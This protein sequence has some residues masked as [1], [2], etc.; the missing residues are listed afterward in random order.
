M[1]TTPQGVGALVS[2]ED[3][4]RERAFLYRQKYRLER[5]RD[6]LVLELANGCVSGRRRPENQEANF[7]MP[8]RRPGTLAGELE[9]MLEKKLKLRLLRTVRALEKIEEGTYG[10]CDVTGNPISRARL[11]QVP[12]DLES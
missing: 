11:E 10:L 12:E 6:T 8:G 4:I 7:P 3:P 9:V 5:A 2:P 1:D